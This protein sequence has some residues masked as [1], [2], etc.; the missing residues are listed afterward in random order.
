MGTEVLVVE[1]LLGTGSG[2]EGEVAT[3]VDIVGQRGREI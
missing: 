1:M 3:V 2:A